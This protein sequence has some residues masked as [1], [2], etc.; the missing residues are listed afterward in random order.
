MYVRQ[1]DLPYESEYD[2]KAEKKNPYTVMIPEVTAGS[3]HYIYVKGHCDEVMLS[4]KEEEVSPLAVSNEKYIQ[5]VPNTN[6]IYELSIAQDIDMLKIALEPSVEIFVNPAV[7]TMETSMPVE[8]VDGES[9][10]YLSNLK[11]GDTYFVLL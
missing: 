7:P 6:Q 11:S 3:R 1:T 5:I 10:L 9:Y 2:N 4:V 8:T